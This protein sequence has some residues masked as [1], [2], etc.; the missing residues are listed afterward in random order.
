LVWLSLQICLKHFSVYAELNEILSQIYTRRHVKFPLFLSEF[1]QSNFLGIF[2]FS[3]NIQISNFMKIHPVWAEL[4]HADGWTEGQTWRSYQSFSQICEHAPKNETLR[5]QYSTHILKFKKDKHNIRT[6]FSVRNA[7]FIIYIHLFIYR[8]SALRPVW[9]ETRAQSDDWYGSGTL[10]PGQIL[11]S[12]LPLLYP[13][14]K[15]SHFRHQVLPHPPRRERS[16]RRKVELWAR[17]LSGNF[18]EMTTSTPFR[19]LLHAANLRH[20]T[21]GFTY[22]PK[23][24]YYI[25]IY[26]Y[27]YIFIHTYKKHWHFEYSSAMSHVIKV[28]RFILSALAIQSMLDRMWISCD[29][30]AVF[31]LILSLCLAGSNHITK[32]NL[33]LLSFTEHNTGHTRQFS[34]DGDDK[35]LCQL[36]NLLWYIYICMCVC[37]CV[38]VC[39]KIFCLKY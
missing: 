38:C 8:Y 27:I 3:K 32:I 7:G 33:C 35:V 12:S 14:F 9:A 28:K 24:G 5:T 4:L 6:R 18:A 15:R 11:R 16:Q 1:N 30:A 13:A 19:D 17:I 20:G 10:H 21:D 2:S 31:V 37:V 34:S 22:P 36:S 25:Y 23:E 29:T 26:I 39:N